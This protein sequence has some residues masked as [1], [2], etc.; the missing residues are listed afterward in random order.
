[1]TKTN[2]QGSHFFRFKSRQP[3]PRW[4]YDLRLLELRFSAALSSIFLKNSKFMEK[5]SVS[6][7]RPKQSMNYSVPLKKACQQQK[8]AKKNN[9]Y[10]DIF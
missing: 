10:F 8:N 2:C 9:M 7:S 6:K 4:S 5:N 1:M 3:L